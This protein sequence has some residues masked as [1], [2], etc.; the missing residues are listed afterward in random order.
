VAVAVGVRAQEV[1][2]LAQPVLIQIEHDLRP[3]AEPAA[4][5]REP[6]VVHGL[7]RRGDSLMFGAIEGAHAAPHFVVSKWPAP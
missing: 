4:A 5:R 3:A 1:D 7:Q 6:V 2:I